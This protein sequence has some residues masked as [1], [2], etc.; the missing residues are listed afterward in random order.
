MNKRSGVDWAFDLCN[1]LFMS[2][3]VLCCTYPF[4]YIFINSVSDPTLAVRGV[5]LL[6]VGFTLKTYAK[7]FV[8][9]D[10]SNAFIISTLRAVLGTVITVFCS[11]FFAYLVTQKDL[12]L[13]KWIYRFVI[14]TMYLNAGLIPWYIT[15]KELGLKNNFLIYI[16]PGAVGAF[17]VILIKTYIE[18]IPPSL[19]E[20]GMIDGAGHLTLFTRIIFPLSMPIIA[21]VA[22]FTAVAQWNSWVDNLFLVSHPKLQ[23]LQ[24]LLYNYLSQTESLATEASMKMMSQQLNQSYKEAFMITPQSVKMTITMIVT[25]PILFVYPFLQKYFVKGIML[26]AVK[27]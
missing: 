6:P 11:S 16:I 12:I 27:G 26:G 7:L 8:L 3:F 15:M 2:L 5:Y 19:A 25:V 21:T 18:Q 13:R 14:M 20:S 4:Y 23:T 9:Q 17:F 24:L 1:W 10:I 22:L